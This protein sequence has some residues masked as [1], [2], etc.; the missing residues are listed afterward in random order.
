[1]NLYGKY[2]FLVR[3][4]SAAMA[5][6]TPAA[7]VS[8][9][10]YTSSNANTSLTEYFKF[11]NPL[12]LS[13]TRKQNLSSSAFDSLSSHLAFSPLEGDFGCY[14]SVLAKKKVLKNVKG[15][16][17]FWSNDV[18]VRN[19]RG[20]ADSFGARDLRFSTWS[21]SF[22]SFNFPRHHGFAKKSLLGRKAGYCVFGRRTLAY[23]L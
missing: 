11:T 6:S 22:Y 9:G 19:R 5:F 13:L 12:A 18:A 23:S 1:M 7:T 8:T 4:F 10:L 21:R 3:F 15:N 2:V 20:A 14:L 16:V 17:Q